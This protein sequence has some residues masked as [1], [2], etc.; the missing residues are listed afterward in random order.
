MAQITPKELKA[1]IS[2]EITAHALREAIS[3]ATAPKPELKWAWTRHPLFLTAMG[4][5]FTGFVA[6]ILEIRVDNSAREADL[7]QAAIQQA[8]QKELRAREAL[9]NLRKITL[10]RA[11]KTRLFRSAVLR[12]LPSSLQRKVDYEDAFEA[13]VLQRDDALFR[14]REALASDP[15]MIT[16]PHRFEQLFAEHIDGYSSSAFNKA[17]ICLMDAWQKSVE[18]S[19][20]YHDFI[21]GKFWDQ[22]VFDATRR[23]TSCVGAIFAEGL[24]EARFNNEKAIAIASGDTFSKLFQASPV[25]SRICGGQK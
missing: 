3:E 2:D 24:R 23:A 14:V 19:T 9:T 13:W 12:E 8:H 16:V 1:K 20:N 18:L 25:P 6:S 5:F 11:L 15:D 21:C 4:F 10:E 17:D 22:D 7:R